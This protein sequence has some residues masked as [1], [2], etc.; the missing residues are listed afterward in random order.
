MPA[1]AASVTRGANAAAYCERSVRPAIISVNQRIAQAERLAPSVFATAGGVW[2][3]R[4]L[5]TGEAASMAI[6]RETA[7][8][9]RRAAAL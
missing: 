2:S 5:T 1:T 8:R 3:P 9:R 6:N 7:P 4:A